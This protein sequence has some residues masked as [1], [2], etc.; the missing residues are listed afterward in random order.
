M[1]PHKRSNSAHQVKVDSSRKPNAYTGNREIA[2]QAPFHHR[3]PS[4]GR[5]PMM[6]QFPVFLRFPLSE[7]TVDNCYMKHLVHQYLRHK[8]VS[9]AFLQIGRSTWK[10]TFWTT[11]KSFQLRQP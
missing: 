2:Y 9:S 4:R 10:Y 5:V 7:Q 11:P 1:H 8:I 3:Q 6:E